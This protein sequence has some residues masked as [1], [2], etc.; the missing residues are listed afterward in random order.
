MTYDLAIYDID[1][2][3]DYE[4]QV[5]VSAGCGPRCVHISEHDPPYLGNHSLE[6]CADPPCLYF[7]KWDLEL[8][9]GPSSPPGNL[10]RF[11]P[12]RL[13][14]YSNTLSRD[15]GCGEEFMSE[16]NRP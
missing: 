1:R 11:D 15:F 2:N 4:G 16:Q 8:R 12:N 10:I 13:K 5:Q 3:K 6:R 9:F 7:V 14:K